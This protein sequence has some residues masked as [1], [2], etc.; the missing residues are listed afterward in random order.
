MLRYIS[1]RILTINDL[2]EPRVL[3]KNCIRINIKEKREKER[4]GK[5]QEVKSVIQKINT[6]NNS[7]WYN[8][9]IF[10]SE[11]GDFLIP[12]P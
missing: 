4:T 6:K 12:P 8:D 5:P 2:N 11:E 3:T 1:I 7:N 9:L 10:H